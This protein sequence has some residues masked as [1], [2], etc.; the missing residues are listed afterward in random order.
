MTCKRRFSDT[1]FCLQNPPDDVD[2]V[3]NVV[4]VTRRPLEE[5][6]GGSCTAPAVI[7]HALSGVERR[8]QCAFADWRSRVRIHPPSF[9][10]VFLF[11]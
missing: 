4:T 6:W 8:S 1:K 11:G 3:C 2:A 5:P 7:K 9:L 10:S